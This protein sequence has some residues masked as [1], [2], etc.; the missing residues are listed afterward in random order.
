MRPNGSMPGRLAAGAQAR[1]GR[2]LG[3]GHMAVAGLL[4]CMGW[5]GGEDLDRNL[6]SWSKQTTTE[7]VVWSY[8]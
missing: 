4:V 3:S 6:V 7:T 2:C 8:L 5:G 1:R